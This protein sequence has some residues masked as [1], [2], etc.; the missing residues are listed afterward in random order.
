[1]IMNNEHILSTVGLSKYFGGIHAIERL[2][3]SVR[4][5]H[6][7]GLIG[8]NGS[9]KTTFFNVV[10]GVLPVTGGK[11]FFD[12]ID[13][14]GLPP[15][16]IANM[17]ISRTFQAGKL[18][19]WMTTLENVMI[20]AYTQTN[21]DLRG[22][23]FRRPL[24]S[25]VQEENMKQQALELLE[26][27]G[28]KASVKRWARELV[29]VERQ[30]V[31][32]A[33][34][35]AAKPKLLLLDEP[36][37]G[38]GT[39]ESVRV[40]RIIRQIRDELGITVILVGHDVRLVREASDWMTCLD[41]GE[42]ISEGVPSQV[43]ND[44]KVLEA[45]LGKKQRHKITQSFPRATPIKTKVN[46]LKIDSLDTSYGVAKALKDVSLE[47]NEG[48]IIALIGANG[49]GKSTL[50]K[51]V[52][53][54]N[55]VD[56]G[57][58]TF[59][60]KDITHMSTEKIVASG[61]CLLPEGRGLLPLMKVLENL[62]LGGYHL[63][64]ADLNKNL[65]QVFD[66]FPRLRERSEQ[67]AG[68]LSGGE[69]QMV[70]I[71]RGLMSSPK[72]LMMDEPSLGLAPVIVEE[73]FKVIIDLNRAGYTILLSEQNAQKALQ[74]AHRAYVFETGRITL[75]GTAQDIANDDK[76]REAYLGGRVE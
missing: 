14:T 41:F 59:S 66:L 34:A 58:V 32:I 3:M 24:T 56:R 2:D 35:L 64:R 17:G 27:V 7:H 43:Q 70:S 39:E 8:P 71:A 16:V 50:L 18:A 38:M 62:R 1:M 42:K 72:L 33:R 12:S 55:Q 9:G 76:V 19:P 48:E 45:Y 37:G 25:S 31:Q 23:F 11:I 47:V 51:T 49:S 44:P 46:V 65:E 52:L 10:S 40:G 13:I 74:C 75:S 6:V 21:T 69:Q 26:L 22:T 30:L 73:L 5:G 61:V 67:V 54:V 53:G 4:K 36:T 57:T 68:T 15:N 60:G 28:L 63:S 20:G 29:W